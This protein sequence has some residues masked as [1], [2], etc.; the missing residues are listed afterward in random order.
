MLSK[1]NCFTRLFFPPPPLTSIP[2]YLS[3]SLSLS[4]S[5]KG[6]CEACD[7][8][9]V[10]V[11]GEK[12]EKAKGEV[13][14]SVTEPQKL[15]TT[16]ATFSTSILLPD[17]SRYSLYPSL[18]P[19]PNTFTLFFIFFFFVLSPVLHFKPFSCIACPICC[20]FYLSLKFKYY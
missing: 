15:S 5:V 6:W 4:F 17:I 11:N 2:L 3:L 8:V 1:Q 13:G 16:K 9:W 14:R 18:P 12:G 7:G 20:Y 19:P 10:S